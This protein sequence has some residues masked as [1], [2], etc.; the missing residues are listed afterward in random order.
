M[1]S[2]TDKSRELNKVVLEC[3]DRC[4][5]SYLGHGKTGRIACNKAA[6]VATVD[7]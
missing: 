4:C 7:G 2:V 3:E 5:I 6:M 1:G